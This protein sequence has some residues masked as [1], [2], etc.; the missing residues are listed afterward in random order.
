MQ[1]SRAKLFPPK[2]TCYLLASALTFSSALKA[3]TFQHIDQF[4]L[5]ALNQ[6]NSLQAFLK[7]FEVGDELFE[8]PFLASEG[9][10]ANIGNGQLMSLV[11]RADLNLATQW[12]SHLPKRVTGP[13]AQ[14]CDACHGVPFGDGAGKVM[15]NNIRDPLH[16]G[17]IGK[18]ITR[19]PPHIFGLG[20][21]QLLAEEMSDALQQQ[22]E[23]ATIQAASS[24]QTITA[25]LSAKGVNFGSISVDPDGHVDTNAVSGIDPDLLVKP[26]EWKGVVSNVRDFV[27]GASNNELGLQATEL[28]GDN[29]DADY[30]SVVNELGVGDITSLVI[31]QAAQ[32]RP[33]TLL[34]LSSLQ[35]SKPLSTEQRSEIKAGET[36]FSS[37]ACSSCHTPRMA[38]N[39]PVFSE[40]SRN[41]R[42]RD[43]LFPAG[44][45]PISKGLSLA[46]AISFDLTKD[47]PDNI[48]KQRHG[49][50]IHLGNFKKAAD[51]TTIV[52]LYGDLKRHDM[53]AAL[54]E[55][56]DEAGT[57]PA[58]FITKELWGVGSTAPYLHDGRATTLDEAI[59][60]HGGEAKSAK[61]N[62]IDL[63]ETDR[64]ALLAFLNN[65]VLFKLEE[66]EDKSQS[67]DRNK[68]RRLSSR[69]R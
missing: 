14:S 50:N 13:N 55:P 15:M 3:E 5:N 32:P 10:G 49:R 60:L 57:G 35:L 48:I 16:S 37:T 42:F 33:T 30:D 12:G 9:A 4:D 31:Y 65:L 54:A 7:A 19:Q 11:P 28:V 68:Q 27:R 2:L 22:L 64:K 38:L 62:Y 52:E 66:E 56:I 1:S 41:P 8:H 43:Q 26:I 39:N 67:N 20:A 25:P 69:P 45:D 63:S 23:L 29:I 36:L 44:Q 47:L 34:E 59:K 24:S 18:F 53:G 40:P 17:D 21:L 58:N 61:Q 46:N 51:G 6:Q